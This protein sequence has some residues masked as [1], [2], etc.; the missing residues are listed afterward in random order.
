M[1]QISLFFPD[2]S[3]A[4]YRSDITGDPDSI[5][6]RRNQII[7]RAADIRFLINQLERIQSR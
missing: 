4:D 1:T 7:T 3:V 2:G 6:I 5:L